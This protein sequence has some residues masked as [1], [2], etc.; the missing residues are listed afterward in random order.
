VNAEN[1]EW[2]PEKRGRD[3]TGHRNGKLV[4]IS[5]VGVSGVGGHRWLCQC[6]CG[7]QK[8]VRSTYLTNKKAGVKSCG[9]LVQSHLTP[10]ERIYKQRSNWSDVAIQHY[11]NKCELCGW[12]EARCDV[13]HRIPY[14]AGGSNTLANAI[15]ICPNCHRVEHEKKHV[16]Y[17]VKTSEDA[18]Q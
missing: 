9:C 5:A 13:H 7:R 10:H 18:R 6:D 8:I 1:T 12:S 2:K 3:L 15:V 17:R 14:A 16:G 11:G 4:A